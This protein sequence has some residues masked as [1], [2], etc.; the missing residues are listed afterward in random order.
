MKRLFKKAGA[1]TLAMAVLVTTGCGSPNISDSVSSSYTRSEINTPELSFSVIDL[2]AGE[3]FSGE[4]SE[5]ILKRIEDYCGVKL[6]LSWVGN[7]DVSRKNFAY[8]NNPKTMPDIMS[9]AGSVTGDVVAAAKNGAFVDL[10]EYIWDGKKYPNLAGMSESVAANLTID[11]KLIGIPRMRVAS[12]YGLSY[13]Q[14]WA[15]KLGVTLSANAT[16]EDVYEMLYAFTYGDPDGNGIDDTIGMEMTNYTGPFDI[17]Q[18]WFGCGNGW[19]M[20]DD[21]LMPVWTTEN[22]FEALNY[23]RRLYENGLMAADWPYRPTDTWSNGCK[24]GENGVFIDVLDS[25]KRIWQYFEAEET[26]TPSVVNPEEAATMIMYGAV[27]GHTLATSEYNGYFTLSSATCNTPEKIEAA[28]SLLDKLNDEEMLVITQYGL[29]GVHFEYQDGKVFDTD[30]SNPE[31]AADYKGLNQMLA[32]LPSPEK[33]TVEVVTNKYSEALDAAYSAA[34]PYAEV[35]P[36]LAYLVMSEAYASEGE[37][38][39]TEVSSLRTQFVCGLLSEEELREKL[40]EVIDN[41]YDR[42]ISEVNAAY[43]ANITK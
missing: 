19:Q 41:G 18:T 35:N 26:F 30:T 22:Y 36:A 40:K 29:E 27:N 4:R 14:D 7:D 12:R 33:A 15:E 1:W 13:R 6:S 23:I 43:W 37:A 10:S 25:G 11:G 39:D 16:P 34:L 5:K 24:V 32:Y 17:I 28:L 20:T 21:G 42:I 8:I 3:S 2:Y 31:L 38:L 9:W